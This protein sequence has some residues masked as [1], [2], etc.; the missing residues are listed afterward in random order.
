MK[1]G[2]TYM[3]L[4]LGA[5][6]VGAVLAGQFGAFTGVKPEGIRPRPISEAGCSP[7]TMNCVSSLDNTSSSQPFSALNFKRGSLPAHIELVKSIMDKHFSAKLSQET[8]DYLHFEVTTPI[9]KYVDD[10][11]FFFLPNEQLI[12]LRSASR[13]GKSDF[14]ANYKRLLKI[15]FH[16]V[17]SQVDPSL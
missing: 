5:L 3:I 17:Q 9:M 16:Y 8:P 15:E 12:Q 13:L 2:L 1:K 10:V 6:V 14:N 7:G 11:E 4:I